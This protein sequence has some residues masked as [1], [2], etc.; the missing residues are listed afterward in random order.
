VSSGT[1]FAK[2][3]AL[4]DRIPYEDIQNADAANLFF[5]RNARAEYIKDKLMLDM[6]YRVAKQCTSGSNVY[7]Y[8]ATASAWTNYSVATPINN[9]NTAIRVVQDATGQRPNSIIFGNYAFHHFS[10]CDQV[11]NRLWGSAGA[12]ANGRL[13]QLQNVKDLFGLERVLVAGTYYNSA[14]EGQSATVSE[15][16]KDNVLL[17][18]APTTPRIDK[19]SFMYAFRW[20]SVPGMSMVAEV[21]TD[22]KRK[23]EEVQLG[24]YQD[25]KITASGL[26]FLITGVGS[27]Q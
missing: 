15:L 19:P 26:A 2:N 9:I 7:S 14:D 27:S 1:Y 4:K 18:Y 24:Y 17:Y 21:F 6:E 12:G 13:V 8:S 25:E 20:N 11:L 23:A 16:W 22:E 5:A 10:N 3:Y